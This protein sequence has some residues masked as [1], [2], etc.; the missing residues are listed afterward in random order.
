V[1]PL[2]TDRLLIRNF[3]PDDGPALLDL[4]RRYQS[5]PYAQFDHRW[6]M[7]P[8]EI[9]AVAEWFASGESSLAVC[10]RSSGEFIGFVSL[11]QETTEPGCIY[12]LGYVF[13]QAHWRHGYATEACRAVLRRAFLDLG[14][15]RV[16]TGTAAANAPSCR[17]L[18]RLGFRQ[19]GES[20]GAF[21]TD[22]DGQPITF[23]GYSYELTREEWLAAEHTLACQN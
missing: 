11:N 23:L 2:E 20:T 22:Q 6:P 10:L 17:L 21:Q 16:V 12:N 7:S 13:H 3:A 15:D 1:Q 19:A 14:A 5:S 9:Q 18:A 8:E 4:V